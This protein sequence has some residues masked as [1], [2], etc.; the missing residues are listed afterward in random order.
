MSTIKPKTGTCIRCPDDTEKQL[1]DKFHC[2]SHYWIYRA[3]VA[4]EKKKKRAEMNVYLGKQEKPKVQKPIPKVSAKRK[5]ESREYTIKRLQFL[6]QPGNQ[7]CLI[8]GCNAKADTIEHRAGRWG[9]NYLDTTTWA[10]CCNFHNLELER[11]PELSQKYQ[12][13]KITGKEKLQKQ[14]L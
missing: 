4:E 12:L 7:K 10:P 1:V 9:D 6:A 2:Q 3:E 5:K 14:T 8:D 11:K 13:S